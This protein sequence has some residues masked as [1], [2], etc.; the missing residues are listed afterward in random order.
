MLLLSDI[1]KDEGN[2]Q[3]VFEGEKYTVFEVHL[4]WDITLTH[5]LKMALAPISML[6]A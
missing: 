5:L 3:I 2:I 6:N 1:K 4:G